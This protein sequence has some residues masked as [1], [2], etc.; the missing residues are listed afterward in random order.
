MPFYFFLIGV[1]LG[2]LKPAEV[3]GILAGEE[4]DLNRFCFIVIC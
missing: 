2:L 1:L 4:I 3:N